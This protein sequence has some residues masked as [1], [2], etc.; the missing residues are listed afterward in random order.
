[1]TYKDVLAVPPPQNVSFESGKLPSNL[2]QELSSQGTGMQ[3]TCGMRPTLQA[4]ASRGCRSLQGS[5][6]LVSLYEKTDSAW[7]LQ[8]TLLEAY[9][10]E[11]D[12]EVVRV[13][14]EYLRAALGPQ[15]MDISC[16]LIAPE[17]PFDLE[18]PA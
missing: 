12:I 15:H 1:M 6:C 13:R 16:V 7:H 3:V 10:R 8:M 2:Q 4:L 17:D 5:V 11:H 14:A 9:C 18:P